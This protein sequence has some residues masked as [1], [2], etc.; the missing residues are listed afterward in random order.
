MNDQDGNTFASE[1]KQFTFFVDAESYA[2]ALKKKHDAA[3]VTMWWFH[4]TI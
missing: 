4:M 3:T 2:S 1:E